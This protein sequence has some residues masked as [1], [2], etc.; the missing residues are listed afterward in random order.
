MRRYSYVGPPDIARQAR[1]SPTRRQITS[2]ADVAAWAR[3]TAQHLD[4]SGEVTATFVIDTGGQ[5]WIAD[6]GSEH[7]ACA[8]ALQVLAAGELSF[9]ING[10]RAEVV[11]ASNQ[12]TG[13]CPE[14]ESWP[15]V[16]AALDA[17]GLGH[18]GAWTSA[19]EFRLCESCGLTNIV[20]D[21]WKWC[22]ACDSELSKA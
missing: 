14:P 22:E 6:R 20:K 17:A 8:Q 12:S 18:S 7:V 3:D 13:F 21:G 11:E 16:E 1:S 4:S 2:Q 5:L 10:Q 15:A 9:R 19:F